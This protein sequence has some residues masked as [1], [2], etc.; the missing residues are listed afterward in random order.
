MWRNELTPELK[1]RLDSFLTS[2]GGEMAVAPEGL[3]DTYREDLL[4]IT[5]DVYYPITKLKRPPDLPSKTRVVLT[6]CGKM[7]VTLV[8]LDGY[9]FEVFGTLGKSGQCAKAWAQGLTSCISISLRHGVPIAQ[10]LKV[11]ENIRCPS[12]VWDD[13][14]HVKSCP[15]AITIGIRLLLGMEVETNDTVST[16]PDGTEPP[17][18]RGAQSG[19]SQP[20]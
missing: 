16:R 14:I 8:T 3:L 6:G 18:Q 13:N 11:M 4:K 15:A 7:Y 19:L 1:K 5:D 20:S 2:I 10:F 9:P 12:S 17:K